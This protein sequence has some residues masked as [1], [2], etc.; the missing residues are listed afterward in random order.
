[1]LFPG[2]KSIGASGRQSYLVSVSCCICGIMTDFYRLDKDVFATDLSRIQLQMQQRCYVTGLSL[3]QDLGD[4]VSTGIS[5]PYEPDSN[6]TESGEA[7]ETSPVKGSFA[8]IRERRKLGK[9]IL[10]AVQ[11]FIETALQMEAE[12]SSRPYENMQSE[13]ETIIEA[14]VEANGAAKPQAGN[15]VHPTDVEMTDTNGAD[16]SAPDADAM[17]VDEVADA[18]DAEGDADPTQAS[19]SPT[20]DTTSNLKE[21]DAQDCESP[22]GKSSRTPPD[23][24]GSFASLG[25][26]GQTGPPTPPQSNGSLGKALIDPLSE[27][28]VLWH[29]KA[30]EPEGTSVLTEHWAGRDAIRMLSEDLTDMD[31]D[32]LKGLGVDVDIPEAMLTPADGDDETGSTTAINAAKAKANKGAATNTNKKRR[33]SARRR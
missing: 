25:R 26:P 9:R 5:N 1:M 22:V 14:S 15:G 18:G 32:E 13:L 23:T 24:N 2:S 6:P 3:A 4:A 19:D 21:A 16:V 30:Y 29:M 20:D 11:P 7:A 17:D 28:G 8:D 10:K 33:T 31:D 27:G 12:I